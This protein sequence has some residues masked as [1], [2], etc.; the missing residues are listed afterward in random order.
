MPQPGR[1]ALALW[2][3]LVFSSSLFAAEDVKV[4]AGTVEDQRYSDARMGGLTIEL[5]LTG[6]SVKEVKALRARV[7]SAKDDRGTNLAKGGKDEKTAD[8]DEFSPDRRP[9]PSLHLMSPARDASTIDVAAEV[10]LFIPARDPETKLI[11]DSFQ[12]RLDKPIASTALR[13]AKAE[14]TPL[15]AAAYKAR[16]AG[17]K[18]KKEDIIAEGKKQGVS[19][20]EIQQA[21][22]LIE[23]FSA[24][25]S[26]EPSETS[27]LV[28]TKDPDGRIISIDVVG[29]DGKALPSGSRGSQGGREGRLMKIDLSSKAPADAALLVTMR[30]SKSVVTLPMN[31][32]GVALP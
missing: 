10:E 4:A 30:T 23:A 26:E 15:S 29:A 27:V 11:V 18:P 1:R 31:L 3:L 7:K 6:E 22:A 25:G 14:I 28:E 19:E 17:N 13:A 24:I 32:K 8:F 2:I 20:A 5:K 16:Q 9:G 21:L 12:S